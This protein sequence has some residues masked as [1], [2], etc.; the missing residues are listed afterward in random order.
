[1]ISDVL[2]QPV[3]VCTEKQATNRGSAILALHAL[4]IWPTLDTVL[5]SLGDN[6]EPDHERSFIYQKGLE[7][8]RRLYESMVSSTSGF[9][10]YAGNLEIQK[11]EKFK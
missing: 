11:K 7:R 1:M 3:E 5:P 8:H 4:N 9:D 2:Q 6:Y 10:R